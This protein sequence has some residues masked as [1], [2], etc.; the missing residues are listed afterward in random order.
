MTMVKT[1]T[2]PEIRHFSNKNFQ[3]Y[4]KFLSKHGSYKIFDFYK[5]LYVQY[6]LVKDPK[7]YFAPKDIK[8]K[9]VQE[10]KSHLNPNLSYS[11]GTWVVGEDKKIYHLLTKY[12]YLDLRTIRNRDLITWEEQKSLYN[13]KILFVGLSVGSHVLLN[14]IRT[15][16]GKEFTIVDADAIELHN[17]N[18]TNFFLDDL[19]VKK[20][21][22]VKKQISMIDP[23]IKVKTFDRYLD[24]KMIPNVVKGTDL[25]V[26]SFDNFPVKLMLRKIAR[27]LNIPV[28]SGFDISKG[29]MVIVER[30]DK[31]PRLGLE[32]YL[33]GYSE[34]DIHE[35]GN[36]GVINKTNLFINIIGRKYHDKKMLDSVLRVGRDLTGYPQLSIA[37]SLT[38]S[39]W[40]AA[41]TDILLN[42]QSQSLRKY[43]N[44]DEVLNKY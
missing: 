30:Y 28:L 10:I 8:E 4:K 44:L 41:A 34:K 2:F 32:L 43:I 39:L 1:Q 25:I 20:V 7:L 3:E 24:E 12:D 6:K 22:V 40:T 36:K 33:N 5:E 11:Y 26:D 19:G 31:D 35:A 37:T 27:K 17:L 9:N 38:S 29:A 16:I 13:K 15:G 14:F 23:Y 42:R 21:D 18:R